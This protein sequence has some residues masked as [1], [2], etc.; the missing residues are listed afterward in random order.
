MVGYPHPQKFPLQKLTHK[1]LW[2][3]KSL[4]LRHTACTTFTSCV[5]IHTTSGSVKYCKH[6]ITLAY[7]HHGSVCA[8]LQPLVTLFWTL[9][10]PST[11][12]IPCTMTW[13]YNRSHPMYNDM[14]VITLNRSHPMYNDIFKVPFLLPEGLLYSDLT[15]GFSC[16]RKQ[17]PSGRSKDDDTQNQFA[18]IRL[19]SMCIKYWNSLLGRMYDSSPNLIR[20]LLL[21][22]S[23]TTA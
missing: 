21:S 8:F 14:I 20:K 13:L 18:S 1:I 4:R 9:W 17:S 5:E 7:N 11:D 22:R 19:T 16:V 10:S 15:A 3:E 6:C 23:T 12:P 2:P